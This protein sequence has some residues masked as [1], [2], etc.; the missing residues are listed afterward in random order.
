MGPYLSESDFKSRFCTFKFDMMT[1]S[2]GLQTLEKKESYMF[3]TNDKI[4]LREYS[5]VCCFGINQYN[6]A[7]A[8]RTHN[9]CVIS[10]SFHLYFKPFIMNEQYRF[11]NIS[12][13]AILNAE[14]SICLKIL[15]SFINEACTYWAKIWLKDTVDQL[16]FYG[17]QST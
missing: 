1:F 5:F 14:C 10:K 13:I 9:Y 15:F 6:R 7:I 12:H 17:N 11:K 8:I 3:D 4:L 2:I 16:I